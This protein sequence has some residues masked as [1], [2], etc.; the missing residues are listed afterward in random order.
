[1]RMLIWNVR[2][3]GNPARRRQIREHISHEKIDI[4]GLQETV[5]S[6]F[7]SQVLQE[8]S[9]GL[10]FS[11]RWLPAQGRSGDIFLG[12]KMDLL[13]MEDSVVGDFCIQMTI[14]NRHCNFR[15]EMICV[16][17][18]AQHDKLRNFIE[19][20]NSI[21]QTRSLSMVIDGILISLETL[22][23]RILE[24]VTSLQWL[25]RGNLLKEIKR[26]GPK[27]TWTN[28]QDQ[29]VLVVL[30]RFLV[31][32]EREERRFRLCLAW[33]LTRV[34]SDHSPII[35]DSSEQGVRRIK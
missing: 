22:V 33:S 19:E 2:G 3:L 10:N 21:C 35:L 30:D 28:K 16:Y 20:L 6:D 34:G 1:M 11:W 26:S 17:G 15:W 7:F 8:I 4:V 29:H 27:F 14:R 32:T 13:E 12:V 25:Y 31:S 18:P 5:K 24:I 9:G 23:R